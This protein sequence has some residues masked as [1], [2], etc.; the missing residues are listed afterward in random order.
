MS[1]QLENRVQLLMDALSSA[2]ADETEDTAALS[3]A[4]TEVQALQQS[5]L[6]AN[7]DAMRISSRIFQA[8]LPS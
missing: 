7:N 2:N 8:L 4:L 1:V 6:Q 3:A 5:L